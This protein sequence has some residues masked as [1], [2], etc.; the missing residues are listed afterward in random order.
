MYRNKM[1]VDI[2]IITQTLE[3]DKTK[4]YKSNPKTAIF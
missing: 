1:S 4:A 2:Q 3:K